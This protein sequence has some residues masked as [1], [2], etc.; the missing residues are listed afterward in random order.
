MATPTHPTV[1]T[2]TGLGYDVYVRGRSAYV[3]LDG[4]LTWRQAQRQARALGGDLVTINTKK[5]NRYITRTFKPLA[6]DPCGLWIGL[7]RAPSGEKNRFVWSSRDKAKY[8]NWVPAGTPG[9][10]KGM[11]SDDPSRKFVHIYFNPNA[12]GYWKNSDNTYHDVVIGGG[13]AEFS[14]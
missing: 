13:I 2:L 7:R 9:Y 6:A 4:P 11:P 10:P 14:L 1:D 8:R 3:L 5:E 12:V